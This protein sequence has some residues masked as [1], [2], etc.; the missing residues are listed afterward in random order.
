[1]SVVVATPVA[2][3]DRI[4]ASR[5]M[6]HSRYQGRTTARRGRAFPGSKYDTRRCRP[7]SAGGLREVRRAPDGPGGGVGRFTSTERSPA[8]LTRGDG[9][10]LILLSGQGDQLR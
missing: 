1:M 7:T 4:L 3:Q 6:T 8:K 5:P 10:T 9:M 2:I